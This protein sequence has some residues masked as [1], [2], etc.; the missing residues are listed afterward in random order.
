M[1]CSL[2]FNGFVVFENFNAPSFYIE[3][4]TY[5][6]ERETYGDACER[7]S[8]NRKLGTNET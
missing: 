3:V 5:R 2:Y 8:I 6:R 1:I 4:N 7:T